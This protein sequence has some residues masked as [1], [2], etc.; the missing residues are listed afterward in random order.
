M[1]GIKKKI[2]EFVFAVSSNSYVILPIYGNKN[3]IS[4]YSEFFFFKSTLESR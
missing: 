3:R 2:S 4:G 1:R